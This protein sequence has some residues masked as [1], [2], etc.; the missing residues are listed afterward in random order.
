MA[1]PTKEEVQKYEFEH[2][3][4]FVSLVIA[5]SLWLN[6]PGKYKFDPKIKNT[7]QYNS[8][9]K[10]GQSIG[11]ILKGWAERQIALENVPGSPVPKLNAAVY[12]SFFLPE[13]MKFL[14]DTALKMIKPG[15]AGPGL[16]FI[17]LLIWGVIAIS[18]F[19]TAAYIISK[20]TVTVADKE[21]LLATT[22]QTLKDLNIPPDKAAQ[23]ISETQQ[24]AS[25]GNGLL[26]NITGGFGKIIPVALL[27]FFGFKLIGS[28]KS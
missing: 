21:H 11:T 2:K 3:V 6:L 22:A 7:S 14:T 24:Q 20:T 15:T 25:D 8:W 19:F 1:I 12:S 16:G 18:A 9:I 26:N 4:L 10:M 23:I 27:A 28:N 17:P 13:K 5:N